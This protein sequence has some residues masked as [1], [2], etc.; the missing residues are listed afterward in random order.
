MRK[1]ICNS[2]SGSTPFPFSYPFLAFRFPVSHLTRNQLSSKKILSSLCTFM[3]FSC[4]IFFRFYILPKVNVLPPHVWLDSPHVRA[5]RDKWLFLPKFCINQLKKLLLPTKTQTSE[6]NES[7]RKLLSATGITTFGPSFTSS[8][9]SSV[10]FCFWKS[11]CNTHTTQSLWDNI[12][13]QMFFYV[14]WYISIQMIG[15]QCK[16]A[17]EQGIYSMVH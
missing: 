1:I 15:L 8:S 16:K 17:K 2:N 13:N 12:E 5:T 3:C 7:S 10:A 9:S 4:E 11:K 14:P 6:L